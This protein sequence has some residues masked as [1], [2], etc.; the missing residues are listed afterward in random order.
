[1]G[2]AVGVGSAPGG[3][4]GVEAA[5]SIAG[6]AASA[7]DEGGSPVIGATGVVGVAEVAAASL[8]L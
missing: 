8:T 5:R 6:L 1:M 2:D 7:D 3:A 4:I